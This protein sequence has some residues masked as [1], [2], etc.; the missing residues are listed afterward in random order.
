MNSG[1]LETGPKPLSHILV[2][3]NVQCSKMFG[4]SERSNM[5]STQKCKTGNE[6]QKF[7]AALTWKFNCQAN[8]PGAA[9][10]R[11]KCSTRKLWTRAP[12]HN[13]TP[14]L[15]LFD[16]CCFCRRACIST[17]GIIDLRQSCEL[18]LT[19]WRCWTT[20]LESGPNWCLFSFEVSLM[21]FSIT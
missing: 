5:S 19:P 13:P 14:F 4:H 17:F 18:S 16:D 12:T 21:S 7:N 9:G 3:L 1:M 6:E 10:S 8:L 11:G 2:T 15:G 20:E